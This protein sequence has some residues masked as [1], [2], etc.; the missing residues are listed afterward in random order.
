MLCWFGGG[1][2]VL[3]GGLG[4]GFGMLGGD[5]GGGIKE[6]RMGI[7][8]GVWVLVWWKLGVGLKCWGV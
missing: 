5:V 1:V 6:C 8:G 7:R 2:R 3:F 4:V